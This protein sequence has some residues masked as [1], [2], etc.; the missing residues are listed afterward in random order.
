MARCCD[1]KCSISNR[2]RWWWGSHKW[3]YCCATFEEY[4]LSWEWKEIWTKFHK[5]F[6]M[7]QHIFV[8]DAVS[9][10]ALFS[11]QHCVMLHSNFNGKWGEAE[12]CR[13]VLRVVNFT[14]K[15]CAVA[16][17][18]LSIEF[19]SDI[20]WLGWE[21]NLDF[22]LHCRHVQRLPCSYFQHDFFKLIF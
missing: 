11:T 13:I 6:H 2:V 7:V 5:L 12:N 17:L 10:Q 3:D 21:K 14:H 8:I 19:T 22:I 9:I 16:R 18:L 1:W 4:T 20:S 15:I